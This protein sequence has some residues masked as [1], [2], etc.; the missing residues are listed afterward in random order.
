[1]LCLFIFD[2]AILDELDNKQDTRVTFIYD[3]IRELQTELEEHGSSLLVVYD[4]VETAWHKVLN[5]HD[6]VTVYTNHDYE[7]YAK[8]RDEQ[9]KALL[10]KHDIDLKT[11]KDQVIFERDEVTKDDGKPYTVFTPY[12]RKWKQ[13]LNDFYLSSYPTK[14]I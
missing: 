4:N 9:I 10:A 2:P 8:T 12:S 7:P 13:K 3:T 6:V 11:Y 5:D 1:V 14:N